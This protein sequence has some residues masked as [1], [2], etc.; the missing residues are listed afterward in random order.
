MKTPI[1][2]KFYCKK[3]N[4]FKFQIGFARDVGIESGAFA[5]RAVEPYFSARLLYDG[6]HYGQS[7]A[8]S[9]GKIVELLEALEQAVALVGGY[10]DAGVLHIDVE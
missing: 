10:A 4:L 9:L 6:F 1:W 2:A 8:S 5:L 7:Q 3:A